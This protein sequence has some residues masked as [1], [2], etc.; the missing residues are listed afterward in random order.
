M[1]CSM[2]GGRKGRL[3]EW[4]I[5]EYRWALG[6][7]SRGGILAPEIVAVTGGTGFIGSHLV[8]RLAS[9]GVPVRALARRPAAELPA[10]LRH[11][12]VE[13]VPGDLS[14][15]GA[16]SRLVRG[17]G[18]VYHLA[19][20]AKAWTRDPAEYHAVN[21]AGTA[22]VCNAATAAGVGR[23]VHTSTNLVEPADS[24][25][26]RP[27]LTAYQQTKAAAEQVVRDYVNGGLYAVIV[28]PA[29][30]FGPGPLTQANSVTLLIDQYR[31]GLFRVRLADGGARA[32]WVFVG[33]VIAGLLLAAGAG[34]A[35]AA[36]TLGGANLSVAEF[37]ALVAE[38][39][40]RRRVVL[41]LPLALARGIAGMAELAA[42]L[43][44]TP[45]I[46]REWVNLFARDWPSS[47]ALAER[48][49]GYAP[50]PLRD[51]VAA[52]VRWLE[53]GRDPW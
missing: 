15:T 42:R 49:L 29:R 44:G 24:S 12:L 19:G 34:R 30:V 36:Y 25:G 21:V 2:G 9:N 28:R 16:L 5:G 52:T 8:H 26:A 33:D 20:C 31:R 1:A 14:D 23:L 18:V 47:S 3:A 37:L 35:G 13:L 48:D 39:T 51:G 50:H 32:N 46:T 17:A 10:P 11:P 4:G 7:R 40:G 41:P 6:F 22:A 43:G 45:F 53:T 27:L 38:V